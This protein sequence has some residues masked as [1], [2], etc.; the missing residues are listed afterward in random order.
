VGCIEKATHKPK[1]LLSGSATGYYGDS[2][3]ALLE[4]SHDPASDF[5]SRLCAAWEDA[6]LRA[7]DD[8]VRVCLLRTGLVLH[9]QGGLLGSMVL[10][11]KSGLG[12]RIGDGHQWMSWVHIDDYIEMVLR[13]LESP[14]ASGP[15]NMT[16]PRPVTHKEFTVTLAKVLHR[17][18]LFVAPTWLMK[19]ILGKRAYLL[20]GGQR[21]IPANLGKLGYSFRYTH[22]EEALRSLMG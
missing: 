7:V 3:D 22:L 13:L 18:A 14:E 10:P 11:F 20:L 4:E 17:P 1:V 6:A 16:A 15:Y 5:G 2:G 21:A 12:A 9:S 19:W 8:H